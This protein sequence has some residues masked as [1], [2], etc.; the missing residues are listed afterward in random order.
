M[1][2]KGFD[3]RGFTLVEIL[4]AMVIFIILIIGAFSLSNL[5]L[6]QPKIKKA[7]DTIRTIVEAA[8]NYRLKNGEYTRGNLDLNSTGA[9]SSTYSLILSSEYFNYSLAPNNNQG[10]IITATVIQ[11][12]WGVN[13]DDNLTYTYTLDPMV[14]DTWGGTITP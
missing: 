11:P 4:I 2:T 6:T 13:I 7:K 5:F 10:F 12:F 3:H 9:I 14:P 8:N 1:A